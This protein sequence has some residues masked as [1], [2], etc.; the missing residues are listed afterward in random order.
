[1]R[2]HRL[3]VGLGV[4]TLT[5]SL[6]SAWAQERGRPQS[7]PASRPSNG[8][9]VGSAAP[10]GGGDSGSSS[11]ASSTSSSSTSSAPANNGSSTNSAPPPSSWMDPGSSRA[12]GRHAPVRPERADRLDAA[13]QRR[14]NGGQTTGRAVPRGEAGG[15]ASGS[16]TSTNAS[17]GS[18]REPSQGH[19]RAVPANSR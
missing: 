14:G 1:M 12:E 4:A 7:E 15:S 13:D 2:F 11:S 9:T 18:E 17:S 10:R 16:T 8:D 3:S 6:S 5:L 19:S